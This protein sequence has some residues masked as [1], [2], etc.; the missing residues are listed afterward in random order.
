MKV[1]NIPGFPRQ[2]AKHD[3][4]VNWSEFHLHRATFYE[5]RPHWISIKF[6]QLQK[7]TL[8]GKCEP[9]PHELRSS[10]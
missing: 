8:G 4:L 2:V 1:F 9:E 10:F 6:V 3:I 5:N 7:N